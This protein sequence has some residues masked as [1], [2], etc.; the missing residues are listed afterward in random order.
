LAEHLISDDN[1][2]VEKSLDEAVSET[3]EASNPIE[4]T[5]QTEEIVE[6]I[7]S[8]LAPSDAIKVEKEEKTVAATKG[9]D[10]KPRNATMEPLYNPMLDLINHD[11][12]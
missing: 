10:K 12:G 7:E 5:E 1:Q 8:D 2:P 9:E 3:I 6:A 11:F 4:E